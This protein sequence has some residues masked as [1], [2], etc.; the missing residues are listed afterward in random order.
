MTQT[1]TSMDGGYVNATPDLKVRIPSS[2]GGSYEI[3]VERMP[4]QLL[5]HDLS[6]RPAAAEWMKRMPAKPAPPVGPFLTSEQI[7]TFAAKR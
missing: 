1:R 5:E 3:E 4:S 7:A 2:R 6:R